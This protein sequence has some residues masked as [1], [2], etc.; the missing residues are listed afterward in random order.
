ML[1]LQTRK[2]QPCSAVIVQGPV[3]QSHIS[4]LFSYLRA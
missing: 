4:A 1:S 2:Q 3:P